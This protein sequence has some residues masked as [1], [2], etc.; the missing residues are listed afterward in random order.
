MQ[1]SCSLKDFRLRGTGEVVQFQESM[2]G[3]AIPWM[4]FSTCPLLTSQDVGIDVVVREI[5]K[6]P[7]NV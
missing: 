3:G 5:Y 2:K 6:A 7:V 1:G 4:V